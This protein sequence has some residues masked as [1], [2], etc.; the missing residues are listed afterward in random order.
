VA[1]AKSI[2]ISFTQFRAFFNFFNGSCPLFVS[3]IDHS[4]VRS[5]IFSAGHLHQMQE[6]FALACSIPQ[7]VAHISPQEEQNVINIAINCKYTSMSPA[8]A[9]MSA[10]PSVSSS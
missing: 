5:D 9:Q 2:F 7:V 4:S 10:S 6:Y 8:S 1:A 3:V